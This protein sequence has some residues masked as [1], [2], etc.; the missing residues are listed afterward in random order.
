M[1]VPATRDEILLAANP[2]FENMIANAAGATPFRRRRLEHFYQA[3]T[4]VKPQL[5]RREHRKLYL[6]GSAPVWQDFAHGLDAGRDVNDDLVGAV[7]DAHLAGGLKVLALLGSAGCGKSTVIRRAGLLLSSTH[8][9]FFTEVED[10]PPADDLP[11]VLDLLPDRPVLLVDGTH[12]TLPW[13]SAVAAKVADH[14]KAPVIVFACRTNTF[15]RFEERPIAKKWAPTTLSV[16]PLSR[17]DIDRLIETLD[18]H[19]MDGRLRGLSM[20]EK[21]R[22]F[23]IR[24]QKQ[25]LVAMRE[26]TLGDGFDAIIRQEFADVEP[27]EAK[28][29]YLCASLPTAVG[30]S[31]TRQQLIA[32]ADVPPS[33]A[34][35]LLDR[36]LKDIV[37]PS[38]AGP[39]V[40]RARHAVMRV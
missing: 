35:D 28:L 31:V 23:E 19:G 29:L 21:R 14:P 24:A 3:F 38:D 16:P 27:L 39:D 4:V 32:C 36:N 9:V 17:A 11:D 34:I 5:P 25:L 20:A 15:E 18:R 33:A 13:L 10:L 22:E 37:V 40:F 7:R 30:F 8:S 12:A 1:S 26:A 2:N 6:L